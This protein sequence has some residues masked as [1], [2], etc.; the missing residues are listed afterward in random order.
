M[1][2]YS[3]IWGVFAWVCIF[4]TSHLCGRTF[5]P[6]RFTIAMP[7]QQ[8]NTTSQRQG[9]R[10]STRGRGAP[11]VTVDG[12]TPQAGISGLEGLKHLISAKSTVTLQDLRK[13][14]VPRAA[15]SV[16]VRNSDR[17]PTNDADAEIS[18][19]SKRGRGTPE[20]VA[21]SVVESGNGRGAPGVVVESLPRDDDVVVV[22][23]RNN[24][25]A[26]VIVVLSSDSD[27]TNDGDASDAVAPCGKS[28]NDPDALQDE[29][30]YLWGKGGLYLYREHLE[31]LNQRKW[32][33]DSVIN[34]YLYLLSEACGDGEDGVG[35]VNSLFP[36]DGD[37]EKAVAFLPDNYCQ[38]RL[39]LIPVHCKNHW[40]LVA[41]HMHSSELHY[42]D[43]NQLPGSETILNWIEVILKH[44]QKGTDHKWTHVVKGGPKQKNGDD[45]GVFVLQNCLCIACGIAPD[46]TQN[47]IPLLRTVVQQE[48]LLETVLKRREG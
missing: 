20:A 28:A 40:A 7:R 1:S 46:F 17:K 2:F 8:T 3:Y 9:R 38:C 22:A 45:C 14:K 29:P 27:S 24:A 26:E 11:K 34:C 23:V 42:W 6:K 15:V 43:S 13:L 44:A 4:K 30:P 5:S 18:K 48:L 31:T 33:N 32:V 12:S 25:G 19:T 16:V 36:T 10:G 21:D 39:I 47:D 37:V 35:V 41:A